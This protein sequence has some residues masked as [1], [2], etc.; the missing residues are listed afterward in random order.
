[1]VTQEQVRQKLIKRTEREKQTYIA[2][3][4]GIP[5]QV[6]SAFKAGKKEL[7]PQHLEL[8]NKYLD[9]EL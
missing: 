9:D 3:T 7:W 5:A 8:L 2:K 1:M 6:I 4:L